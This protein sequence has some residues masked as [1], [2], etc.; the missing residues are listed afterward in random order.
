MILVSVKVLSDVEVLNFLFE[1]DMIITLLLDDLLAQDVR[2]IHIVVEHHFTISDTEQ[3]KKAANDRLW[4]VGEN[5]L[6][7]GLDMA[8]SSL[9]VA[10]INRLS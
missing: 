5:P 1:D 4:A 7:E 6:E 3:V 10:V 9:E 8:L 2:E